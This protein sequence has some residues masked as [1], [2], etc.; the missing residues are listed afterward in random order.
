MAYA[1]ILSEYSCNQY[2]RYDTRSWLISRNAAR[3]ASLPWALK[4][5]GQL[6]AVNVR[7][8]E[9]VSG[10]LGSIRAL[11]IEPP[12]CQLQPSFVPETTFYVVD[13]PEQVKEITINAESVFPLFAHGALLKQPRIVQQLG[14][15]SAKVV[16]LR[17]CTNAAGAACRHYTLDLHRKGSSE[18]LLAE[19]LVTSGGVDV[20]LSP[21]FHP[22]VSLYR[23]D[24]PFGSASTN[25]V[26]SAGKGGFVSFASFAAADQHSQS[27]DVKVPA[28]AS[29]WGSEEIPSHWQALTTLKV[30]VVSADWTGKMEYTVQFGRAP[31]ADASLATIASNVG[32]PYPVGEPDLRR[33]MLAVPRGTREVALSATAMDKE[34][35]QVKLDGQ[36]GRGY[37]SAVLK[38]NPSAPYKRVTIRVKAADEVTI[39]SYLLVVAMTDHSEWAMLEDLVVPSCEGGLR[40]DFEMDVFHYRCLLANDVEALEV[41]PTVMWMPAFNQQ[42]QIHIKDKEWKSGNV[43]QQPLSDDG[44]AEVDITVLASDHKHKATY[45]V[46]AQ[47]SPL[48]ERGRLFTTLEPPPKEAPIKQRPQ[49]RFR[50]T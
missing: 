40:P 4:G 23:T 21:P 27:L 38:L 34:G 24:V 19:L 31:N 42:L 9:K 37:A 15:G 33:Y 11:R 12:S 30:F 25:V 50:S 35:A 17:A 39:K 20:P 8:W 29:S 36:H 46:S 1:K 47:G 43:F 26:A 44:K 48:N 10:A 16:V 41:I 5:C 13:C 3:D 7:I 18:A 6:L 32:A 28:K 2:A 22:S 14:A 49:Y 45:H